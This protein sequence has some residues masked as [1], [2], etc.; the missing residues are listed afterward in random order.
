[1]ILTGIILLILANIGFEAGLVFYDA[2][3]PEIS[4][5]RT[6]GR[7]SGYGFA[8]GYAGSLV[9]LAIT[10]P[11]YSGGFGESNLINIRSSFL[12]AAAF[13]LIF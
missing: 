13:F 7:V 11:L 12:L 1:M 5:E 8:M 9:T 4:T 10:Y 6:Y 3:L 2:F